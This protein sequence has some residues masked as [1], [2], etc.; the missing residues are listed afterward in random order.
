MPICVF[1][2]S[3]ECFHLLPQVSQLRSEPRLIRGSVRAF[4]VFV[5]HGVEPC[6]QTLDLGVISGELR[7][8]PLTV[9]ELRTT[10]CGEFR[11][12]HLRR[13]GAVFRLLH[14]CVEFV[15][16]LL[17]GEIGCFYRSLCPARPP[18]DLL[19]VG[20]DLRRKV[21]ERHRLHRAPI[22]SS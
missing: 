16:G 18:V 22:S 6:A 10:R 21:L 11:L 8:D 9:H 4:E 5:S 1:Y 20:S 3:G 13:P 15:A 7:L 19:D 14:E 17:V 2:A 12:K